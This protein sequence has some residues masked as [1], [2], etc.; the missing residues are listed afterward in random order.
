MKDEPASLSLS[1]LDVITNSLGSILLLFFIMIAV[2]GGLTA[3]DQ[4]PPAG[5][6]AGGAGALDPFVVVVAGAPRAALFADAKASPWQVRGA[7]AAYRPQT[8][9]GANY[10]V[11][12][13]DAP[14]PAG[15]TVWL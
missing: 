2:R 11:F 3:L 5:A 10:A 4:P 1:F 14:P 8:G 15:A 12:L 6:D 7:P 9:A 13:A